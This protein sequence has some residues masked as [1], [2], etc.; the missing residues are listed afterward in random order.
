MTERLRFDWEAASQLLQRISS[1]RRR[2]FVSREAAIGGL[3]QVGFK[4]LERFARSLCLPF[5][6]S[7]GAHLPLERNRQSVRL[8]DVA[9]ASLLRRGAGPDFAVWH[10]TFSDVH[11]AHRWQRQ[12]SAQARVQVYFLIGFVPAVSLWL[13]ASQRSRFFENLITSQGKVL[14]VTA[15]LL[16]VCGVTAVCLQMRRSR[17]GTSF[18]NLRSFSGKYNFLTELLCCGGSGGS[19]LTRFLDV[20]SLSGRRGLENY[21]RILNLGLDVPAQLKVSDLSLEE[22]SYLHDLSSVFLFSPHGGQK[23]LS[24]EHHKAFEDFQADESQKA[25]VLSLRLLIPMAIFFLPALFLILALAGFSFQS[26]A[27][28]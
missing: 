24:T 23:W 15:V 8:T 2:G 26:D 1:F 22:E 19:K 17:F 12:Q 14:L 28:N 7:G 20:C 21:A 4:E 25:A 27:L 5:D 6:R 16:F 18:S 9:V 13:I 11:R 10:K 3:Q